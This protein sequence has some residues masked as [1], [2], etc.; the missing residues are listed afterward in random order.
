MKIL[1]GRWRRLL[2]SAVTLPPPLHGTEAEAVIVREAVWRAAQLQQMSVYHEYYGK[3]TEP[4]W[5]IS[6]FGTR[7]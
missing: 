4:P 2:P 7:A 3:E 5:R 6:L 1:L